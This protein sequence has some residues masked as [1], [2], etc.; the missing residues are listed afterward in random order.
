MKGENQYKPQKEQQE[1]SQKIED[2]KLLRRSHNLE[3]LEF[4]ENIAKNIKKINDIE[5]SMVGAIEK[6]SISS[7]EKADSL[8]EKLTAT[9]QIEVI[10][11]RPRGFMGSGYFCNWEPWCVT[12]K[13]YLRSQIEELKNEIKDFKKDI[14]ELEK[15]IK[16][17]KKNIDEL[18]DRMEVL[19][20][21]STFTIAEYMNC[22][23]TL[24]HIELK[25]TEMITHQAN[26]L[27]KSDGDPEFESAVEFIRNISGYDEDVVKDVNESWKELFQPSRLFHTK[28]FKSDIDFTQINE[29]TVAKQA[30]ENALTILPK[31]LK[32]ILINNGGKQSEFTHDIYLSQISNLLKPEVGGYPNIDTRN[33]VKERRKRLKEVGNVLICCSLSEET[34]S[35]KI[36]HHRKDIAHID[37]ILDGL[38]KGVIQCDIASTVGA[39]DAPSKLASCL[40]GSGNE[41]EEK[42]EKSVGIE[43][44][45]F[46]LQDSTNNGDL[47]QIL[48][49]KLKNMSKEDKTELNTKSEI[50][51][52]KT[53]PAK[54]A[55]RHS[56]T[57]LTINNV[58]MWNGRNVTPIASN[59]ACSAPTTTGKNTSEN[60]A[61]NKGVL[62][63]E[64]EEKP[65][66]NK[67]KRTDN[68]IDSKSKR[69]KICSD[70]DEGL[71]TTE[72]KK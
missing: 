14:K 13:M 64:S 27:I 66:T 67:E 5:F 21:D 8:F 57:T 10:K 7:E 54:Q 42:E 48:K 45:E 46:I 24:K 70:R 31:V 72:F 9:R 12:I 16:D 1:L 17:F 33:E 61:G 38:T 18:N 71:Y 19:E 41:K 4:E 68:Q 39:S 30:K 36:W 35:E 55:V 26:L 44:K 58:T 43:I 29:D 37:F 59:A 28:S 25:L 53:P 40:K 69:R 52:L 22:P 63:G 65:E 50:N 20:E 60:T 23:N 3:I 62:R 49:R 47:G 11:V 56:P 6:G 34:L 51:S 32:S 2:F 15:D